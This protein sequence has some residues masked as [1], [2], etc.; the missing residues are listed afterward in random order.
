[1]KF[2]KLIKS[3]NEKSTKV[4]FKM[5]PLDKKGIDGIDVVAWFVDNP[6]T[7]YSH[8]DKHFTC[9]PEYMKT[10]EDAKYNDYFE[11][12]D[13]L[14][15]DLNYKLEILNEDEDMQRCGLCEK[16]YPISD[17][18]EEADFGYLCEDCKYALWSRGEDMWFGTK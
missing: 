11:L 8:N 17:L 16:N 13:E 14:E 3:F 2:V 5:E 4:L 12:K 18:M 9:D 1:M 7:C 10:L 6:T 15:D